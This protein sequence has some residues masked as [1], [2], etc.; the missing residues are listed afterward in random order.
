MLLIAAIFVVTFPIGIVYA[1]HFEWVLHRYF[2]HRPHKYLDYPFR[3]HA[4]THHKLYRADESYHYS[5]DRI[6]EM[7]VERSWELK[8]GDTKITM[9]WWNGPLIVVLGPFPFYV[10]AIV[11]GY[12]GMT[13]VAWTIVATSVLTSAGYYGIYEYLHYCMHLPKKRQIELWRVFRYINGHHVLH[14]RYMG[15]NFNVVLP[16]ADLLFGTL[17]TRSPMRFPQVRGPSVPDL[18]PIPA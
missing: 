7:A 9:A 4:L 16:L 5:P 13:E 17:L 1:S 3:T 11:F 14:H 10:V 6:A 18:Q 2:M 12:F 8:E 15:K